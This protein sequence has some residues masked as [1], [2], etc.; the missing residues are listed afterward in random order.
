MSAGIGVSMTLSGGGAVRAFDFSEGLVLWVPLVVGLSIGF[1]TVGAAV[2]YF[3]RN[4]AAGTTGL[5]A[6]LTGRAGLA[7]RTGLAGRAFA[8]VDEAIRFGAGDRFAAGF[9]FL[10]DFATDGAG[11]AFGFTVRS[12]RIS[13]DR[14][15]WLSPASV[16]YSESPSRRM[17][18]GL[19]F[20]ESA[21]WLRP[22][23]PSRK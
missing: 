22:R 14:C 15:I 18:L 19:R 10:V 1:A 9:G 21:A 12:V 11:M 17:A 16:N 8:A 4:L 7:A 3:S 5:A 2:G 13:W 6:G 20:N 23:G